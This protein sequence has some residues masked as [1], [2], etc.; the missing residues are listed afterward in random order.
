MQPYGHA[1]FANFVRM[2]RRLADDIATAAQ[3]VD[4]FRMSLLS[5]AKRSGARGR[6]IIK[7]LYL[8]AHPLHEHT[9]GTDAFAGALF[10][11]EAHKCP[12]QLLALVAEKVL[13]PDRHRQNKTELSAELR[14]RRL[15][16]QRAF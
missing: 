1:P 5:L 11:G 4:L 13:A 10:A 16:L 15:I 9:V 14:Q 12:A 6:S 2:T 8:Q 7:L 3:Q